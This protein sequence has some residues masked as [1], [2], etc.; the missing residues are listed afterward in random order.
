MSAHV[1]NLKCLFL[2]GEFN[3]YEDLVSAFLCFWCFS[4]C[5]FVCCCVSF[6]MSSF[7]LCYFCSFSCSALSFL[8]FSSCFCISSFCIVYFLIFMPCWVPFCFSQFCCFCFCTSV[9]CSLCV[10]IT[11]KLYAYFSPSAS[12]FL[13]IHPCLGHVYYR[14]SS[15]ICCTVCFQINS[16]FA[17]RVF[18][19][20][21]YIVRHE[22]L[23]VFSYLSVSYRLSIRPKTWRLS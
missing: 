15:P 8:S 14:I 7:Y 9:Y 2:F 16:A 1:K 13:I 22:T 20:H 18:H 4:L 3:C 5:V 11:Q 17:V 10:C 19:L 12:L 6:C 23:S 21:V